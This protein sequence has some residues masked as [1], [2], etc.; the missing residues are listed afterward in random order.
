[1]RIVNLILF[2]RNIAVLGVLW[3]TMAAGVASA[4]SGL[5]CGPLQIVEDRLVNVFGESRVSAGMIDA[6]RVLL[7]Y[8]AADGES[9]TAVIL[10]STD[11]ACVVSSGT[12]WTDIQT[13]QPLNL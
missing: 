13:T 10:S 12:A 6:A 2:A 3:L 4:Q 11:V 7:I 8:A 1:M 9:W 5:N